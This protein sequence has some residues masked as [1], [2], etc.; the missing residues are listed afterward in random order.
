LTSVAE[1]GFAPLEVTMKKKGIA[2]AAI[3]VVTLII[4]SIWGYRSI[5]AYMQ[6]RYAPN[7]WVDGI[8]CTGR[9]VEDV[10]RQLV[11]QME[12]PTITVTDSSGQS[13][14]LDMKDAD[15]SFDFSDS[16]TAYQNHQVR[17]GWVEMAGR[18]NQISKG[19]PVVAYDISKV[20]KWWNELPIVKAEDGK[21]VFELTYGDEGYGIYSTLD[22]HLNTKD[23]LERL[24]DSISNKE[25]SLSL[26]DSGC[27]FDYSL[28]DQQKE[29]LKVY[30]ELKKLE[31]C[32]LT[33]D[34]G[35]E[36]IV[37]DEALM[38]RFIAKDE[39]GM[40]L[41]N[42]EGQFYYDME[43]A[44]SYIVDLC[45]QYHTYGVDRPFRSSRGDGEIVMVPAGTFGTELDVK[46]EKEFFLNYLSDDALRVT[47]T[48]HTPVYLHE[49]DFKGL[50]DV[51]GTYVE[52]DITNQMLYFYVD[53]ELKIS[54]GV[55]TGNLRTR[56]GTPT[57]AYYIYGKY[58]NRVL[59]GPG[60][61]SFVRRWM[62]VVKAIGLHDANWRDEFGG[63]IYKTN[64]SHGCVNMPD[65]TTDI[66]FEYAEIG[67]PVLIYE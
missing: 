33:Y 56:H 13:Y 3:V 28:N 36:K 64:G 53:R 60:Y 39:K 30:Q 63:E 44:E 26:Q 35:A 55:V 14:F 8:Y 52:V 18:T 31:K 2:A 22:G 23:G 46:A 43:F 21:T 58:K 66:I 16:L 57:G 45:E 48:V 19:E 6:D 4:L 15:Y 51:G 47:K 12:A 37:F 67:T 62:P 25:G 9:T 65:E 54:S 42:E 29:V 17:R 10:N 24:L 32:G 5:T 1:N 61:A 38:S 50:D 41:R 59:R 20:E 49:T 7:T 11:S 40:P 34:M 27:Y